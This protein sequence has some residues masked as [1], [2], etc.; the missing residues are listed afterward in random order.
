M[1]IAFFTSIITHE[2]ITK[3]ISRDDI[4]KSVINDNWSGLRW[5]GNIFDVVWFSLLIGLGTYHALIGKMRVLAILSTGICLLL[6]ASGSMQAL[7]DRKDALK[8]MDNLQRQ[9][10]LYM[11]NIDTGITHDKA[12]MGK[13]SEYSHAEAKSHFITTGVIGTYIDNDGTIKHY[14]PSQSAITDR[15]HAEKAAEVAIAMLSKLRGWQLFG[16]L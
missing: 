5:L 8:V 12:F 7:S 1:L 9:T 11:S 16:E 13:R 10:H 3:L 2:I 14:V 15:N 6:V 4:Y